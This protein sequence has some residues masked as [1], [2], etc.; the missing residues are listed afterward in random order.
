[1]RSHLFY[2]RHAFPNVAQ[3][4]PKVCRQT[5]GRNWAEIEI[6]PCLLLQISYVH[7]IQDMQVGIV[8]LGLVRYAVVTKI[9]FEIDPRGGYISQGYAEGALKLI[10]EQPDWTLQITTA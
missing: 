10:I 6:T 1:M 3:F 9:F 5:L 7:G 8:T 4:L 2:V